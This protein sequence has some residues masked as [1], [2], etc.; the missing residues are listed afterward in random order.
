[1]NLKLLGLMIFLLAGGLLACSAEQT[2][3]PTP[4]V[5]VQQPS[6]VSAEAFVLPLHQADLSFET[7]GR[8]LS[9]PVQEGQTVAAGDLL[10]QL[11]DASQQANLAR[12]QAGLANAQAT[13]ANVEA[14]ATP[15]QLAQAQAGL[16]RAQAAL[17]QLLAGPT[18]QD[19]AQAQA[20]VSS[21]QAGLAQ[22]R[23]G[24]RQEEIEAAAARQLQAEAQVRLAQADYDKY[25]YGEPDVAEP[26][27]VALQQATLEYQAAQANYQALANG[28]TAQEVAVAQATVAEAQAS[29]DKVL[30]GATPEQVAQGQADVANAQAALDQLKAGATREQLAIAQAGVQ[31]AQAELLAAQAELARTRLLAP[32]GGV[33]GAI[34][35]E[36]GEMAGA[37]VSVL[38]LGD[39]SR[40]QVETD[41]LTEIDVV[42]VEV[43]QPVDISVDA[44]PQAE[45]SGRVVRIQPQSETKAG[46]V[47][48]TVLIDIATGD[49][50]KLR[51]GMTTFVDVQ[52]ESSLVK[53]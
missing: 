10:L 16:A 38:S 31:S 20:A 2:P 21:A 42:Q 35:V 15:Q 41:D 1:M 53:K 40:W 50:S 8:V 29:L 24:A 25:V 17:A 45:F 27:G 44:L 11:D 30:A 13:L 34:R 48:Y 26:Y 52:V 5:P 51:W 47:T 22:V 18:E 46:D 14:G 12:A 37:G 3:E 6:T 19:I 36:A 32:F 9:I 4:V 28:P 33:V 23:A 7:A 39:T 43:G 49:T